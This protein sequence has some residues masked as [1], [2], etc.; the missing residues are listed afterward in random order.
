MLCMYMYTLLYVYIHRICILIY[1]YSENRLSVF[2]SAELWG[3]QAEP[4][5]TTTFDVWDP[6]I[7]H[8]EQAV[9][10]NA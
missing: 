9:G 2:D 8:V 1:V 10:A 5:T 4:N 3:E 7:E 6:Y